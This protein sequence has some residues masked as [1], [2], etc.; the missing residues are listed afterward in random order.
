MRFPKKRAELDKLVNEKEE[1]SEQLNAERIFH[2]LSKSRIFQ[3][4]EATV[5]AIFEVKHPGE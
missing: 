2:L 1:P 4:K 5:C 3:T